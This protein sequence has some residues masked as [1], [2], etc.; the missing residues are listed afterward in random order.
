MALASKP[1][2]VTHLVQIDKTG[3]RNIDYR[4]G[5]L[6]VHINDHVRFVGNHNLVIYFPS[7]SP[8]AVST[9]RGGA[10]LDTPGPD[11]QQVVNGPGLYHYHVILTDSDGQ[12][13]A[14]DTGCPSIG[15]D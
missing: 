3:E 12:V 4:P 15:V 2:A 8:F 14:F 1:E 11:G 9:L 13:L 10:G 7:G 6:W 5:L